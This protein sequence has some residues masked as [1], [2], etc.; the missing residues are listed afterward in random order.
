MN[1]RPSVAAAR[2]VTVGY[3]PGLVEKNPSNEVKQDTLNVS[4]AN[5]SGC[6][7]DSV[8]YVKLST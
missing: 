2:R 7:E 4:D 8:S 5:A 3:Q 1:D 6:A